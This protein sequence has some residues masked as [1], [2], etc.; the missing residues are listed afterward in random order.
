MPRK[1]SPAMPHPN[2]SNIGF[3]TVSLCFTMTGLRL[4]ICLLQPPGQLGL[5]VRATGPNLSSLNRC[6]FSALPSVIPPSTSSLLHSFPLLTAD[7]ARLSG[8]KSTV[9]RG[10]GIFKGRKFCRSRVFRSQ[11]AE[12]VHAMQDFTLRT[13]LPCIFLLHTV[14]RGAFHSCFICPWVPPHSNLGQGSSEAVSF[15]TKTVSCE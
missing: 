15:V 1:H 10:M 6:S 13:P 8:F 12:P 14:R 4:V 5:E 3:G 11:C 2:C 9:E 7:S